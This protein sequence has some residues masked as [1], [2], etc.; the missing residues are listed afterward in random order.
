MTA[1][2]KA[3]V[4]GGGVIG[5]STAYHLAR[6]R[7]GRVVVF[8]KGPVGDGSSSRA[9]GIIT[10]L[11]WSEPGVRAR[12]KS[13]ELYRELSQELAGYRFQDVGCLNLFDAPS[14]KE[15]ERLLPLY[16]SLSV[17]YEILDGPEMRRRWPDLDPGEGLIGLHDPL[18][19]YSEPDEYIPALARRNREL[20]VE[21]R[22]REKVTGFALRNGRV[23]GVRTAAGTEEADAV[24][25]TVYAWTKHV[26]G[27]LGLRFP[28]KCFVHQRWITEALPA[29]PAIPAVNAN[30]LLGYVRPATGGRLLAGL[31]TPERPQY[32]V[33][34]SDFHQSELTIGPELGAQLRN[35]LTPLLPALA[36]TTWEEGR[37]GLLTF[38]SDGEPIL[39]PVA[40][41]PG[42]YVALAFHSGGFAYNPVAGFLMAEYVADG[43]T[44]IDI[45]SFSPDRFE[46][47][48][49]EEFLA[50]T[51][52]SKDLPRRR[53]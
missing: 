31:E 8:D 26:V 41:V 33:P 20:G 43:R 3:I 50:T 19:G 12:K 38:S 32:E 14:W 27:P 37:V 10:D 45:A 15:R 29:P 23:A 34:S 53:H 17:P 28:V 49:T 48:E 16:T 2:S 7:F 30:P 36:S 51:I 5:L 11:L 47:R 40:E 22:E 42:F 1:T 4:I 13:L 6:K 35:N 24:I 46:P 9:A 39:G 25:A 52:A 21:I 44:S 18:G